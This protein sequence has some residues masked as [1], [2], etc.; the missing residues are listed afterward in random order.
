[1][2][3]FGNFDRIRTFRK[4]DQSFLENLTKVEIFENFTKSKFHEL[5]EKIEIFRKFDKIRNFFEIW[6]ESKILKISTEIKIF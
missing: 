5:F 4:F 3:I 2:V 6:L 1:M